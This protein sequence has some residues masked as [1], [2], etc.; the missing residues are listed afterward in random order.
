M[1]TT[2]RSRRTFVLRM[3]IYALLIAG[4]LGSWGWRYVGD[5]HAIALEKMGAQ[6]E[7][8]ENGQ[9]ISAILSD[10]KIPD[11]GLQHLISLPKLR[12]LT[13]GGSNIS[14]SGLERLSAAP[15]LTLLNLPDTK[16][17]DKGLV[18]LA[19][20]RT[21][22][23]LALGNCDGI[24]NSGLRHLLNVKSLEQL[25]LGGTPITDKGLVHLGK[26][27]H[28]ELLSLGGCKGITD[29]GLQHLKGLKKLKE[30]NLTNTQ[31]TDTGVEE[32]QQA[33]PKCKIWFRSETAA[34]GGGSKKI[35]ST[36]KKSPEDAPGRDPE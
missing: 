18:H 27:M 35:D 20:L 25:N 17:T 15:S 2:G 10:T 34:F 9:V 33:L 24:T 21:L 32:I 8:D 14:D 5:R 30:L 31:V 1:S 13:L 7:R 4:A 12:V 26:H 19:R 3:S 28:L 6:F 23:Q 16:I 11:S 22:K 29:S 36:K